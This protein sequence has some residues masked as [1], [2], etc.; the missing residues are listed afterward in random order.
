MFRVLAED[1]AWEEWLAEAQ[2]LI[3]DWEAA[4]LGRMIA[5]PR[6]ANDLAVRIAKALQRAHDR[7]RA[8][9]SS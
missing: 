2:T 8:T 4:G 9:A 7:G 3:A 1:T 6:T 5:N